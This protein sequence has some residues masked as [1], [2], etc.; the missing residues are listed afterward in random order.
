MQ[1][2]VEWSVLD[3][4]EDEWNRRVAAL[5][6]AAA[7]NG[8]PVA[9]RPDRPSEPDAADAANSTL[10]SWIAR[11]WRRLAAGTTLLV[12]LAAAIG[13]DAW[14]TAQQG[15]VHIRADVANVVNLETIKARAGQPTAHIVENV[16]AV[17]LLDRA[18]MAQVVITQTLPSGK[19]VVNRQPRFYVQTRTGWQRS[20]PVA[21]FW[22]PATSLDTPS[23]HFIF[24]ERDRAAITQIAPLAE[25]LYAGMIRATGQ[26]LTATG[27]LTIE[28]V[29]RYLARATFEGS[30]IQVTSPELF[31]P[32]FMTKDELFAR[33]VG[34]AICEPML[35][36]VL[37]QRPIKPQWQ[38]LTDGFNCRLLAHIIRTQEPGAT[39]GLAGDSMVSAQGYTE[40]DALLDFSDH[41]GAAQVQDPY[42]LPLRSLGAN[43]L[44][45]FIA[46]TYGLDSL[47]RLLAGFSEYEDWETLSPAILGI[48]AA[49][50]ETAW[51]AAP[52]LDLTED[53]PFAEGGFSICSFRCTID[54]LS[55]HAKQ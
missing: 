54:K 3:V 6:V 31:L 23:L 5:D 42:D 15:L 38:P 20:G 43:H 2:Q 50:L 36:A 29:P 1:N 51:R 37:Q 45:A 22:E 34:D 16:E 47:P 30:R 21:A 17:E 14:R 41:A 18:A 44:I 55:S 13:Y 10:Q 26:R 27:A 19:L 46:A 28:V 7:A 12:L 48:S 52:V 49:E 32:V 33:L 11:H 24:G 4:E 35:A 53:S 40:L 8:F 39:A 9:V 25:T